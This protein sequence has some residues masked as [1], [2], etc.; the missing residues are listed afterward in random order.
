MTTAPDAV[1]AMLAARSIALV[2]AS[3][4]PGSFGA[5]MIDEVTRGAVDRSV[6]LVNPHYDEIRGQRSLAS[7]KHLDA[8]VDLALLGV[9]DDALEAQLRDAAEVGVRSAVIFGSAHGAELRASLREIAT[10]AGMALCGA[11]CMGF[12]NLVDD[13]RATGYIERELLPRGPIAL[14]THSGSI[15]S[16]LLR[17]RRALGY[18]IAVSSGQE[19]V[20]TTA[21][22][23]DFVLE[24][25]DTTVLALVLE[26]ARD[27][28]RFVDR[29][30]RAASAGISTVVLPV[31][32]SPLGSRLVTAH[33]GALAGAHA[34]WAALAEGTGALV[35]RDLAEFTDTLEL[36]AIGRRPRGRLGIASVHDS[37]AERTMLAD[38][39]HDL[40]V[41]FAPLAEGTVRR[42]DALIDDGLAAA[43]PLDLWGNG[44]NTRE[45]FAASLQAMADDPAVSLVALAVDLVEEYDG[46]RSYIEAALDV[47]TDAPLVVLANLASAID[48]EAASTLRDAGIPVLE[49]TS[50]G[51]VAI[52]HLLRLATETVAAPEPLVDVE[53]Q[54]RWRTRLADP[55]PLRADESFALLADYG[56]PVVH[57]RQVDSSAAAVAAAQA[58][59]CPVV[60][61]TAASTL[62]H[63][64]DVGAV[65]LGVRDDDHVHAVYDQLAAQFGP[66]VT[67]S[68]TAPAGVEIALGLAPDPYL[69]LL[70]V[71]G[72]GGIHAELVQDIA[73]LLPPL[74]AERVHRALQSLVVS[75]LLAGRRGRPPADVESLVD[76]VVALGLLAWELGDDV[77]ALDVNPIVASPSGVVAVD[78]F[79]ERTP[80]VRTER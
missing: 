50:S 37:G 71:V 40:G 5:R 13:L 7:L 3:P 12:V 41:P 16:A 8:P 18:T 42:L 66:E 23:L 45:L 60:V 32:S 72:A 80:S 54:A 57:T 48:H 46:D 29:L 58:I 59:G 1:A 65:V 70:V 9:N 68:A 25:T 69:G 43:N 38:R 74:T 21:D 28:T 10:G 33:S 53:R 15:F 79:V 11:G 14:V 78:V 61:K 77:T 76:A 47:D 30:R 34:T 27:G 73:V 22:Y 56:L 36:L 44:A 52:G 6:H 19:L 20:T 4:R 35:V 55:T 51:L 49:G 75:D 62:A 63:K 64:T 17:T 24:H 39:A 31:G 2:G 67:V 26:A